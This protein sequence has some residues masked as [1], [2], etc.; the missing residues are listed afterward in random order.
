MRTHRL[1]PRRRRPILKEIKPEQANADGE[2]SE[3]IGD[4][5]Q[6]ANDDMPS[7]EQKKPRQVGKEER[8]R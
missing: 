1:G 4:L 8:V 5:E 3:Q 6:A 7:Q 2:P